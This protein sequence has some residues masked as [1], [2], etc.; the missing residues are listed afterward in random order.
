MEHYTL[1]LLGCLIGMQ[2]ALEADHLSAVAA[3]SAR[4]TSRRALVLRGA[5]WGLGHSIT[6]LA[7]CGALLLLGETIPP[8]AEALL[9]MAVGVMIVMLGGN[10]LYRLWRQRPHVHVHRHDGAPP[11]LHFHSHAGDSVHHADSNH[12]HSH[13]DLGLGRALIVGMMHGAAGS[14][15][16]MVLAAAARSFAEAAGYIAAFG[17]G[18]II[19]MAALSFAASYPLRLMERCA[20]G[21]S[22]FAFSCIG[23]AAMLVGGRLITASWGIL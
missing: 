12:R 16:L 10:M 20:S 2:H 21:F 18:S 22:T 15:G 13:R 8:R 23:G 1:L 7:V 6:L 3:L 5:V 17:F 4:R 11:H 9:E 19:G 14:A